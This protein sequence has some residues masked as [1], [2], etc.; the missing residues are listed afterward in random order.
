MSPVGKHGET[1]PLAGYCQLIPT[2]AIWGEYDC[3]KLREGGTAPHLASVVRILGPLCKIL[4]E[5]ES[6]ETK[7]S[8]QLH[9]QLD[10][11]CLTV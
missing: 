11:L 6:R 5:E 3:L 10:I 1:N 8:D 2:I 4:Q 9:P 7:A